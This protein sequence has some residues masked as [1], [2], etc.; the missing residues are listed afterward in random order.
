[1]D[2][3][4]KTDPRT[5]K[6]VDTYKKQGPLSQGAISDI[7]ATTPSV[8]VPKTITPE[9]LTSNPQSL[10]IPK[11]NAVPTTSSA[12][13]GGTQ[14][15]IQSLQDEVTK[16]YQDFQTKAQNEASTTSNK[17]LEAIGAKSNVI[18]EKMAALE[19][20][21]FKAKKEAVNKVY[22][23]QQELQKMQM[24]EE[25]A[26]QTA[27]MTGEGARNALFGI[28]NKY[29]YQNALLSFDFN[30]KQNNYQSAL[31]D[32]NTMAEL[33]ME[34]A[35]PY[36]DYYSKL[37]E[38][39]QNRLT[40][41]QKEALQAKK[42]SVIFNRD[43]E[44]ALEQTRG[45]LLLQAYANN[46]PASITEAIK[47][48]TSLEEA[49][50]AAGVYSGDILE[51]QKKLLEIQKLNKEIAGLSG[52]VNIDVSKLSPKGQQLI[53][54]VK[55]LRFSSVEESKRIINNIATRLANGDEQGAVGELKNFGY[56]K[57]S[58]GQK[59]DYDNYEGAISSFQSAAN[60]INTQNI[61][62]GPYKALA[63]KAKPYASI[64]NDKAYTDLRG[65]IELGQAQLRKGFYGT[66]VTGTEAANAR[67]FLIQDSDPIN[68]IAWKL[69]NGSNF[70][71]F[72]N[73]A[74][75]ARQV[76]L[77]KPNLDDYITYRV[78]DNQ[79]GQV[80]TI[81]RSEY[82]PSIYEILNQ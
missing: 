36:I 45:Q 64:K 30:A 67:N 79:T 12:V 54:S 28:R 68:V 72:T 37:F 16:Q 47:R 5:Q 76:G 11:F 69:E 43:R 75:I 20:P 14:S 73:D 38:L 9:S 71:Q 31:D 6:L 10:E 61:V 56:Q 58:Q 34:G 50:G 24:E 51:R 17:L 70:L 3:Q 21:E 4:V 32:I 23:Q 26:L 66:A 62:A 57:M 52:G 60:Q 22:Q 82:D 19:T 18:N 13:I 41:A 81:P 59:T 74:A 53:S 8:E 42:D 80:G 33:K 44:V 35:Q 65:I 48:A 7:F 2:N 1:M 15:K 46:A 29:A 63:E 39:N 27:N 40:D 49:V 78:R 77:S 55:N 25:N